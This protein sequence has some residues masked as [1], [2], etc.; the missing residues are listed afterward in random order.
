MEHT[1][2][3]RL[4]YLIENDDAMLNQWGAKWRVIQRDTDYYLSGPGKYFPTA[5]EAI[6]SAIDRSKL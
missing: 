2:T 1:D 5:R 4:N 6:D 3:E